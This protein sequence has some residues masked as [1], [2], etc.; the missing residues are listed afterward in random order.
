MVWISLIVLF[1]V[2]RDNGS[3]RTRGI[4]TKTKQNKQKSLFPHS[5]TQWAKG[6][7]VTNKGFG[8]HI[9]VRKLSY[10]QTISQGSM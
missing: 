7:S 1:V 8:L 5:S 2:K 4:K 3:K 6:K 10:N 9:C